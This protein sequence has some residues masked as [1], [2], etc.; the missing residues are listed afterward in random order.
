MNQTRPSGNGY[1]SRIRTNIVRLAFWNG[2][3]VGTCA[4][5]AFGPKVLWNRALLLTLLAVGLNLSVGVGMLL[6]NKKY[7]QELDELQ[8]KVYLNALAT[9]VGVGLI[10]SVPISV[11]SGYHVIPF[12][13]DMAY[14]VTLMALT[15]LVS[16]LYGTRRY[17]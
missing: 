17:R 14:L 4:L 16:M 13:A 12:K 3:W 9:T 5:M 6:A 15:F 11:M 1:Q 2:A 8:R 10:A 7:V